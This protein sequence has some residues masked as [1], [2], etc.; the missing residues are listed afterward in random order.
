MG[1]TYG[2]AKMSTN[3]LS[4]LEVK[5][6]MRAREPGLIGDGGGLYLKNGTSWISRGCARGARKSRDLGLGA[7]G[8]IT[9]SEARALAVEARKL[10]RK[11]ID[12]VAEKR[13]AQGRN[14]TFR[15][16]AQAYIDSHEAGWRSE[17]HRDQWA[18]SLARYAYPYIGNMPSAAIGIADVLRCLSPI[19]ATKAPTASRVRSR[20]ELVLDAAKAHGHRDGPNPA[21]WKGNLAAIL[22]PPKKVATVTHFAA[23]PFDEVAAFMVDLRKRN[24]VPERAL[25]FLI[26]TSTRT[27]E[28]LHAK[29][30]E[31]DGQKKAVDHPGEPDQGRK[32]AQSPIV[33]RGAR[34][35]RRHDGGAATGRLRVSGPAARPTARGRCSPIRASS[36][37]PRRLDA[38]RVS[39]DVPD[40]G[41]G[42]DQLSV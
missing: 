21:S 16:D 7:A 18:A 27:A 35:P 28:V 22:P 25:E 4:A 37:M 19:W 34:G 13:I 23:M 12:P 11:G 42:V 31:I 14:I 40:V 15:E 32:G 20:I 38:A 1:S 6:A 39:R 2:L 36:D 29:W 41:F 3:K 30:D 33:R 9:L 10:R 17:K 24:G 26:L 8:D 5:H